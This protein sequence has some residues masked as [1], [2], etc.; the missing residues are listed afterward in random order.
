MK[1]A[2]KQAINQWV[3]PSV[4]QSINQSIDKSTC[5]T[6]WI[7]LN[8][9]LKYLPRWS[10]QD[11]HNISPVAHF[12]LPVRT[13]WADHRTRTI[14][15]KV[16]QNWPECYHIELYLVLKGSLNGVQWDYFQMDL[17]RY[18]KVKV[19]KFSNHSKGAPRLQEPARSRQGQLQHQRDNISGPSISNGLRRGH[20]NWMVNGSNEC[21]KQIAKIAE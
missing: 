15:W 3:S 4:H 21:C 1:Q 6:S 18:K 19:L 2:M 16:I 17:E 14:L 13:P 11:R 10:V 20:W 8:G 12:W 7:K 9:K 5:N